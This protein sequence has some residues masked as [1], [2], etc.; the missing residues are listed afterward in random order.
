MR[1]AITLSLVLLVLPAAAVAQGYGISQNEN[2]RFLDDF[3]KRPGMI[4][5]PDGVMYRVIAS[6]T[7]A[8]PSSRL[9]KVT[10]TYSGFLINNKRFDY[11]KPGKPSVFFISR[12]IPGWAEVLM[13][14][15]EGDRWEVII[16]AEQAYGDGS[17]GA[18]PPDQTLRFLLQLDHVEHLS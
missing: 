11:S 9:D 8:A 1:F 12:L 13:K 5:L 7:G 16:P 4:K 6:G 15:H 3:A 14:M 2:L 18:V 10:V 17:S